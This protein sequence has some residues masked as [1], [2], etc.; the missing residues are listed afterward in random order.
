MKITI[1]K[2]TNKDL[3]GIMELIK[4]VT[5]YHYKIDKYYKPFSKYKGLDKYTKEQLKGKS[6]KMLVA[7]D[8]GKII[9][10]IVGVIIKPPPYVSPKKIGNI[11]D[12]FIKEAYRHKR[13]GEKLLKELLKWFKEKKIKH[14]RLSVDAR[15]KI[16]VKAWK[17]FGFYD[18]RIEMR[19]DL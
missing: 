12:I 1:K 7:E 2:A 3:S 15:N 5:D 18:Y 6:V 16:G 8:D 10:R 11:D 13:T 19:K 9:G 17:K 14:I 4:D